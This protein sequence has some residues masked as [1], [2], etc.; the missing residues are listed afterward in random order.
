MTGVRQSKY[1]FITG[2]TLHPS[3]HLTNLKNLCKTVPHESD[4][5]VANV[6]RCAVPLDGAGGIIAVLEVGRL[7]IAFFLLL[8]S[9]QVFQGFVFSLFL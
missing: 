7:C 6:Q 8:Q 2:Q 1:R 5:F 4:L 3:Q 9:I